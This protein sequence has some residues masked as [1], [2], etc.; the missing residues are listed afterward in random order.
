MPYTKSRKME[1]GI[2]RCKNRARD[3]RYVAEISFVDTE[4]YKRVRRW[5]TFNRLDL[6][7]QW[8]RKMQ[9]ND[10][11]IR[12]EAKRKVKNLTFTE[13]V[14]QYLDSWALDRKDSTIRRERSRIN[15]L[16]IPV[17]G[18]HSLRSIT[19]LDIERFLG[20]R[21]SGGACPATCNRD[22]CRLK[23]MFR[24]AEE[25]GYVEVNPTAHLKQS[26]ER[27]KP[28][29]FLTIEEVERLLEACEPRIKPIVE[30]AA[31]TGMRWGEIAA[32]E[33][34]DVDFERGQLHIRDPKNREDRHVPMNGSVVASLQ[35]HRRQQAAWAGKII[36]HVFTN[37]RLGRPW[38]DIRVPFKAAL[39]TAGID[40][41]FPFKNLRHTAASHLTM[42]GVDLRTVGQILGH[43]TAHVTLR[44]AHL[45]QDH[46]KDAVERLKFETLE[47]EQV[48]K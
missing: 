24:K 27:I 34:R 46:L 32:L 25:W 2:W 10:V 20:Q 5:R 22:L 35:E 36:S 38:S 42:A 19:Q 7:R 44:Y 11:R 28:Q 33:W 14:P 23:N 39:K 4:T 17:L 45:S 9:D 31:N 43:K 13:F 8:R 15:S 6:A 37:P 3:A 16:L 30:V 18:E 12:L 47:A 21:R 48:S 40:E 26:P 29:S 41:S 1:T